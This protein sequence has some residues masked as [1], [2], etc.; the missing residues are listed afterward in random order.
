MKPKKSKIFINIKVIRYDSNFKVETIP[1]F[2]A[3]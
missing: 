3:P 1:T 2:V